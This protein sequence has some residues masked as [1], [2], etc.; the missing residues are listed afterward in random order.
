MTKNKTVKTLLFTLMMTFIAVGTIAIAKEVMK[1]ETVKI[2]APAATETLYFVGTNPL[3]PDHYSPNPDPNKPC[4]L[5]QQTICQIEAPVD[6]LGR[7]IMTAPAGSSTVGEEIQE[8][9]ASL[10]DPEAEEPILNTT[11]K[12][13]R[14]N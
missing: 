2:E 4:G 9:L 5:P 14:P 3:N 8:S 7:P 6:A 11:V 1:K 13:F 10:T 12:D